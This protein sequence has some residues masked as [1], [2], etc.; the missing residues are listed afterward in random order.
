MKTMHTCFTAAQTH[1]CFDP[2]D[3][4]KI[5]FGLKKIVGK[6]QAAAVGAVKVAFWIL[7]PDLSV[8][9]KF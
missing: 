2:R 9:L 7:F 5:K 1:G 3:I 8:R 4:S 6:G